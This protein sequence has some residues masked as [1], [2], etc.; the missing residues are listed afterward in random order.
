LRIVFL[1]ELIG[2]FLTPYSLCFIS[3]FNKIFW[4]RL[5]R[6]NP[7]DQVNL[8]KLRRINAIKLCHFVVFVNQSNDYS[9][10]GS[11]KM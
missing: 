5:E 10:V 7:L 1:L 3:Q 2:S 11:E 8:Y 9:M 6:N 4:S